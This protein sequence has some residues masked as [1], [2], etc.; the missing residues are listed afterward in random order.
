M[1][2]S[3]KETVEEDHTCS[4]CLDV[5]FKPVILPRCG[6]HFCENC[7]YESAMLTEAR[8]CP[9]CRTGFSEHEV[10]S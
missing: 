4:I 8:R 10:R 2:E 5:F 3:K 6:H 9:L 7:L 1:Q